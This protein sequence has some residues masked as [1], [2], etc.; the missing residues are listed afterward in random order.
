MISHC[1][2]C[3]PVVFSDCDVGDLKAV[4]ALLP[5]ARVQGCGV[6]EVAVKGGDCLG[7]DFEMSQFI[8]SQI[9]EETGHVSKWEGALD[10]VHDG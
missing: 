8:R 10:A 9:L 6:S 7:E 5:A 1:I 2:M 3:P 4:E